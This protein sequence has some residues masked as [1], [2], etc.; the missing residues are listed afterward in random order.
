MNGLIMEIRAAAGGNDA[1][2]LVDLF[3]RVY[4]RT[5]KLERL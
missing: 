5:V 3:E 4:T 2:D 1:K